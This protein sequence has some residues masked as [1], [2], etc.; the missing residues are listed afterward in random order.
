MIVRSVALAAAAMLAAVP[1]QGQALR[2]P[3]TKAFPFSVTPF[4]AVGWGGQRASENAPSCARPDCI[5]HK[6]GIGPQVGIELQMPLAGTLGFGLTAVGGKPT[7][8]RC[9]LQCVSPQRLTAVHGTALILW[10]FKARAPIYFGIGP[11][12]SYLDP[13]PVTGQPSVTEIG[14]ALVLAYD[15]SLG[16]RLGGRLG[17]WNYFVRPSRKD[18]PATYTT[19]NI[20]WDTQVG[21]GVRFA[22]GS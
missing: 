16:P 9:D 19:G 22:L 15:F 5:Q 11:A 8:V 17:W 18:L 3:S 20:A 4:I 2:R 14:G 1:A 7:Q 10:R 12:V 13:G 21:L 6:V